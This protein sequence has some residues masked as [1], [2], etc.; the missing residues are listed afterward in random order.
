VREDAVESI[1]LDILLQ[2]QLSEKENTYLQQK[3]AQLKDSW[4]KEQEAQINALNLRLSQIH[5]RLDRLTDA[6]IDRLIEK[7]VF[8]KRK[9]TLL[10]EQKEIKEKLTDLQEN[11]SSVPDRVTELVELAGSAYFQYKTDFPDGKRDLLKI[12]T[13][14]RQV[15]GKNIELRLAI[16]FYEIANRPKISNGAPYREIGRTMDSIVSKIADFVKTEP[17]PGDPEQSAPPA[18]EPTSSEDRKAA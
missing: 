17:S 7:E 1:V 16:P 9:S 8:E 10:I 15:D 4:G 2:L 18:D 11:G 6:Y 14:N 12:L 5:D 3:L 13:S